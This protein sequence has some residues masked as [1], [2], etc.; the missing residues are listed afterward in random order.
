MFQSFKR[1]TPKKSTTS[2]PSN[3]NPKSKDEAHV[4]Y[5]SASFDTF[6]DKVEK[7]KQVEE[8]A[9]EAKLR[10]LQNEG[11]ELSDLIKNAISSIEKQR[12][13]R[14]PDFVTYYNHNHV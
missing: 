6:V 13:D 4:R 5:E 12:Y 7:P 9:Y 1:S 3:G 14:D 2:L 10:Q 8:D 11:S